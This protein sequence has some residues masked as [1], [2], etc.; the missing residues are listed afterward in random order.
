MMF[1]LKNFKYKFSNKNHEVAGF[2]K[3][4]KKKLEFFI[5]CGNPPPSNFSRYYQAGCFAFELISNKKK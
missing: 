3:I 2:V 1:F 4:K 5:D